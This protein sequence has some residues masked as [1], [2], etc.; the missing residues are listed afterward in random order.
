MMYPSPWSK[1]QY[2]RRSFSYLDHKLLYCIH[3]HVISND[4]RRSNQASKTQ[5][6]SLM[7]ASNFNFWVSI[8]HLWSREFHHATLPFGDLSYE[9]ND[10]SPSWT[11]YSCLIYH[12]FCSFHV[13]LKTW[14]FIFPCFQNS[15]PPQDYGWI[16][17]Y[18]FL[19]SLSNTAR[20]PKLP[21]PSWCTHYIHYPISTLRQ[22]RQQIQS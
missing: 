14:I 11:H 15:K 1:A 12:C 10:I 8:N 6:M 2:G 19:R 5:S 18:K 22:G 3:C 16:H 7:S 9:N 13:A 20:H 4:K 17:S 21:L